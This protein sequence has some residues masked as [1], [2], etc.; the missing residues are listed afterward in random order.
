MYKAA[1]SRRAL[2]TSLSLSLIV[3]AGCGGSA[4]VAETGSA[5]FVVIWPEP[6]RLIPAAAQSIKL[7]VVGSDTQERLVPR[8]P[9]GVNQSV[10]TF[11]GLVRGN[12]NVTATAYPNSDGTGTVQATGSVGVTIFFN[13]TTSA[14]LTM[15]TT[16][17]QVAL[18]PDTASINSTDTQAVTGSAKDASG[19][20]VLTDP[21]AWSWTSSDPT[22]A[23]VTATGNPATVTGV[24]RGTVTITGTETESGK[25]ATMTLTVLP[26]KG[27]ASIT[28][29]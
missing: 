7:T 22:L 5:R 24:K 4:P 16:I 3:L 15:G 6:S 27:N 26:D 20:V 9:A 17:T 11:T 13:Q 23:T 12:Y 1:V 19:S 2:L 8:P 21:A 18:S 10:V 28:V 14:S 25:S 29:K